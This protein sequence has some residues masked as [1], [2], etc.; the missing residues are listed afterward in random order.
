MD[1]SHSQKSLN[2]FNNT[3]V[4]KS[5]G[6]PSIK[7]ESSMTRKRSRSYS[8]KV[9]VGVNSKKSNKLKESEIQDPQMMKDLNEYIRIAETY[10]KEKKALVSTKV[11]HPYN[12][13]E[14]TNLYAEMPKPA[15]QKESRPYDL[16][17]V[18][19]SSL[20][21]LGGKI[22]EF[23]SFR[24]KCDLISLDQSSKLNRV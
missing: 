3:S 1:K 2:L 4:L 8:R 14:S 10:E 24:C 9:S 19:Q 12:Q 5:S 23:N 20:T 11:R 6:R 21:K 13:V 22:L 7:R 18:I 15:K 16:K 17:K